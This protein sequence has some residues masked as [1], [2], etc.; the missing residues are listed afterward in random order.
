MKKLFR[1][2]LLLLSALC[3]FSCSEKGTQGT[4]GQREFADYVDTRIGAEA[5][6][7]K[8]TLSTPEEPKGFVY[9]GVGF[10]NPMVQ[11]TPQTAKTDRPYY[12]SDPL[13]QGFRASHYPNG[14]AM[15][16]YGAITIMPM[17]GELNGR[18]HE[19]ASKYSHD[20]EIAKPYYY[21]VMLENYNIQT[22][23]TGVSKAGMLRFTFPAAEQAHIVIDNP[24]SEFEN[25]F[26]VIPERNEIEGYN[27]GELFGNSLARPVD[28]DKCLKDLNGKEVRLKLE[29][30]SCDLYSFIF[31]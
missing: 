8:S 3:F 26:R 12:S 16:E 21:S 23:L 14:T 18:P 31:E 4:D 13:L 7:G 22:E 15:S 2:S 30:S 11:L 20:K 19:R 27:S 17:V 24:R 25:Y 5:W 9:P 1:S 28:F 6:K 29:F 10:T